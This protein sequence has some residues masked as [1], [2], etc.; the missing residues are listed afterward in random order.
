M[1][2]KEGLILSETQ[3]YKVAKVVGDKVQLTN[4]EGTNIVVDKNYIE[5]CTNSADN[6]VKTEKV[7]KTQL[8]EKFLSSSRTALTVCYTKQVDPKD[9][10]SKIVGITTEAQ[11][12]VVA[13]SLVQGEERVMKGRHYHS[14]DDFGRVHFI[15]ME[16]EKDSSKS[17]DVRQRLVDPRDIKWLIVDNVKYVRK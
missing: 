11:A 5:K 3:F 8:A 16:I 9:V 17:Y 15:D 10:A 14:V 7:N 1:E 4:D 6:V 2:I 12:K 13:K